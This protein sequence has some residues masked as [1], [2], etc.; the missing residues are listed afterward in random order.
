MTAS[1]SRQGMSFVVYLRGHQMTVPRAPLA[2][3]MSG[4][5]AITRVTPGQAL[6]LATSWRAVGPSCDCF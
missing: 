4:T 5:S 6:W 2:R 3:P 1:P